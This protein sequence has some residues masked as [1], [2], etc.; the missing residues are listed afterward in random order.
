MVTI[1]YEQHGETKLYID[2]RDSEDRILGNII[3]INFDYGFRTDTLGD[4]SRESVR[5]FVRSLDKI[6]RGKGRTLKFEAGKEQELEEQDLQVLQYLKP[7]VHDRIESPELDRILE[8]VP[9]LAFTEE[10]REEILQ[11]SSAPSGLR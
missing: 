1:R 4:V 7:F 3:E 8:L 2:A 6:L 10:E 9:Q 11:A 5:I